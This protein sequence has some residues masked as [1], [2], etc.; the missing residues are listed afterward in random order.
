MSV[1]NMAVLTVTYNNSAA[2]LA[3]FSHGLAQAARTIQQV[4]HALRCA[5]TLLYA[6]N[7]AP[8]HLMSAASLVGHVPSQRL[9]VAPGGNVGYGPAMAALWQTAFDAGADAIVTANPDGAFHPL[10]LASLLNLAK[11]EPG[12]LIEARQFPSEHPKPYN[13]QTLDTPWASGCCLLVPRELYG[14]VGNVDPWF[15][16]YMEDVDYSWRVRMAGRRVLHCASALY[17]HDVAER[18]LSDHS[19]RNMWLAARRLGWKWGNRAFQAVADR[20]G[21]DANRAHLPIALPG[22]LLPGPTPDR[23]RYLRNRHRPL[24]HQG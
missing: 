16:L 9:D 12:N 21:P 20:P 10:C 3:R 11:Q 8:S 17:A 14:T 19:E 13:L 18:T 5:V 4:P 15:W 7:G 6:D 24:G 22:W 2:E 1:R 23:Q